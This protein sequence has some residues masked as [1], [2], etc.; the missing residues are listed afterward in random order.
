LQP[1]F[2]AGATLPFPSQVPLNSAT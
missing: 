1:S 2:P